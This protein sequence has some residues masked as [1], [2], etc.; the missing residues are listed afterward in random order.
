MPLMENLLIQYIN[1]LTDFKGLTS[2]FVLPVKI[3]FGDELPC[4]YTISLT[5]LEK[6][7]MKPSLDLD[8]Y[9]SPLLPLFMLYK[10]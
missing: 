3:C 9:E 8:D 10:A 5:K 7:K 6:F 1:G 2:L 4:S